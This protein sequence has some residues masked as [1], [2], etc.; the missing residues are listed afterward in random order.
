MF[1]IMFINSQEEFT[2]RLRVISQ[3]ISVEIGGGEIADT[4]NLPAG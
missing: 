4:E 1:V 2:G 3:V